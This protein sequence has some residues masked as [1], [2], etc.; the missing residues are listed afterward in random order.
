MLLAQHRLSTPSAGSAKRSW[1]WRGLW[2]I[3]ILALGLGLILVSGLIPP[4]AGYILIVGV[5]A[6]LGL[7]LGALIRNPPGLRDHRQ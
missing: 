4:V 5:C 3:L 6:F 7:A 1:Q 2:V